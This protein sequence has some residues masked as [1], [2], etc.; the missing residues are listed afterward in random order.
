[1]LKGWR[2]YA[3]GALTII[4]GLL[5]AFADPGVI[6]AMPPKVLGVIVATLGGAMIVL[7][8]ITTTPPGQS[9]P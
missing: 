9:G 1:M 4:T 8:T 5:A 2:T 6:A 3:L 7:R